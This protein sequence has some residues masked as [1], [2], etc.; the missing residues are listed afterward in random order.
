[1]QEETNYKCVVLVR[2]DLNMTKGKVCAQT[3]HATIS[4]CVDCGEKEK[5]KRWR[6]QG[7]PVIVLYVSNKSAMDNI[8]TI[9]QRKKIYVHQVIDAGHTEVAPGTNTVSILG[10]DSLTKIEKLTKQL[11]LV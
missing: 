3:A 9:A 11:K 4:M 5:F 1:M 6:T 7:E 10:P 8:C 2:K